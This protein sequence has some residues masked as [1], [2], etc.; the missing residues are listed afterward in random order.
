MVKP[1]DERCKAREK[2][3]DKGFECLAAMS[4]FENEAIQ[5]LKA[6]RY[7]FPGT[8]QESKPASIEVYI[9]QLNLPFTPGTAKATDSNASSPNPGPSAR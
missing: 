7:H 4:T 9:K 1:V 3:L 6:N 5:K 2:N 8:G